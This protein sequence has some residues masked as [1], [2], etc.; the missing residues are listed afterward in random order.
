MKP[1][2]LNYTTHINSVYNGFYGVHNV[3]S[4]NVDNINKNNNSSINGNYNN[5]KTDSINND[6]SDTSTLTMG[7]NASGCLV[8]IVNVTYL[9]NVEKKS[10]IFV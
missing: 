7:I 5:N 9:R 6:N 8:D 1:L 2:N 10:V 4:T 3:D